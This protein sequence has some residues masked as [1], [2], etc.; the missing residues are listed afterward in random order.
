MLSV[1][2][3]T[4]AVMAAAETVSWGT[5]EDF[6]TFPVGGVLAATILPKE[7]ATVAKEVVTIVRSAIN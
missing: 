4:D 7:A 2:A 1:S 5:M 3:A 6:D